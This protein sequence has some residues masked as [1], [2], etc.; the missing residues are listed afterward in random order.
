MVLP[1]ILS[2]GHPGPFPSSVTQAGLQF[3]AARCVA[4]CS[5]FLCCSA[6]GPSPGPCTLRLVIPA[7]AKAPMM[8]LYMS[9]DWGCNPCSAS[10]IVPLNMWVVSPAALS[11]RPLIDPIVIHSVIVVGKERQY[12]VR[13]SGSRACRVCVQS[14][15]AAQPLLHQCAQDYDSSAVAARG[16]QRYISN[17]NRQC[18]TCS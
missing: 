8:L 15:Q 4:Q 11:R 9:S 14:M 7:H 5:V 12:A 6:V 13:E 16:S 3:K 18:V 2:H 1:V 10:S 17:Q